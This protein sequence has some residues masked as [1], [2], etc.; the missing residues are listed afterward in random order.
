MLHR[1][2]QTILFEQM[3]V[4]V[5]V[6]VVLE[7]PNRDFFTVGILDRKNELAILILHA[8][9]AHLEQFVGDRDRHPAIVASLTGWI[10][11]LEPLLSASFAVAEHA[12]FLD[13]QSGGQ[14]Q[15]GQLSRGGWVD[16]AD[17]QELIFETFLAVEQSV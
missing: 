7:L 9:V 8:F 17:D 11:H 14:N 4:D 5:G 3:L 10:D 13:P 15:I 2:E 6:V 1:R 16:F 12:I